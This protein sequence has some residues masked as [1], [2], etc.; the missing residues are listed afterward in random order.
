[1]AS[2]PEGCDD[3]WKLFD[4]V[5]TV[6]LRTKM[7]SANADAISDA[8]DSELILDIGQ[9]RST[10]LR[11]FRL[12]AET[13]GVPTVLFAVLVHVS[14][15]LIALA[16]ALGWCYLTLAARWILGHR[17]PGTLL[18]FISMMSGRAI[19]ALATSSAFIYLIQPAIGSIC[20]AVLFLGSAISGRPLT[21]RLARDFVTLPAHILSR[22]RV[23][24][25]FTQ[26]ALLWGVSRLAD[27]GMSLGFLRYGLNA[28][29]LSRGLFSPLLTML[30][31]L[32]CVVWGARALRR[33]GIR[34]R[35]GVAAI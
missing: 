28:G 20:M 33:D 31:I 18:V 17:L 14:G 19:L 7:K 32:I 3:G 22:R 12:F 4:L 11:A 25:M 15:L 2:G 1:M 8:P 9:L 27:A 24:R 13:I 34:L 35:V 30:T 5:V 6:Q 23:R 26:I 16:A 10:A 29:L 21:M